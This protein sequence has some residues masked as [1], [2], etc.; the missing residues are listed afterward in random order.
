MTGRES[1][2][3]TAE[4]PLRSYGRRKGHSLSPRQ[5]RLLSGL[6]PKIE[7][8]LGDPPPA[9]LASLFGRDSLR[10]LWLEIGFGGAEHLLWQAASQPD[11]GLIGCEPF[12][13]GVV[14]AL[15]G[16]EQ[17]GLR[18]IRLHNGD[19]REVVAWL[20]DGA[21]A[22]VFLL[23]PDPWPKRRHH[24]R[25]LMSTD[26]LEGL[27][28]ILQPGGELRFATDSADYAGAGLAAALRHGAFRWL[29]SAPRD[30]RE[31]PPDWPQ[32]RYEQKAI[33][34]GRRPVYLRFERV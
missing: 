30:W 1:G 34:D 2:N 21:V 9:N 32:T 33:A 24:K 8:D 17:C 14:K 15:D 7:L 28:R 13:N 6:L 19:A 12:I 29:A 4:G 18:N 23:F 10:A 5:Q 26:T 3:S 11:V 31:R 25:R 20:P 27:A 16:I 22:R